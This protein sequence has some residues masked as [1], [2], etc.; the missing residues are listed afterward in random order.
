MVIDMEMNKETVL[1]DYHSLIYFDTA[2]EFDVEFD[3]E[4]QNEYLEFIKEMIDK[5]DLDVELNNEN[6]FV[7]IIYGNALNIDKLVFYIVKDKLEFL[8]LK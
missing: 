7:D 2:L 4:M 5:Y 6:H 3:T 1:D 8:L